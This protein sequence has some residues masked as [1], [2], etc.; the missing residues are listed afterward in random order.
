MANILV[1]ATSKGG[2]GKTTLGVSLASYWRDVGKKI[3]ILDTDPNQAMTRWASKG[4]EGFRD[5]PVRAC[6]DEHAIIENVGELGADTDL[7]LVDT[8]GFGNQAMIYAVGVADLVLVPVMADEASLLEAAK[9]KKVIDSAS[10]LTRRE[11]AFRTVL[12]RVKRMTTVVRHTER[13]LEQLGLRPASTRIGDR[14]VF[15][16]SSYHGDSPLSLSPGSAAATEVRKLAKELEPELFVTGV[17]ELD[18]VSA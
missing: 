11:I 10:I 3:A 9:M 17:T 8:A 13:N 6:S 1:V 7:V 12:N 2:T 4:A 18:R 14:V 5:M 15:Q 16:E